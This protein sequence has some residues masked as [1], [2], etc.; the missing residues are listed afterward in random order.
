MKTKHFVALA[1]LPNLL[2]IPVLGFLLFDG[3]FFSKAPDSSFFEKPKSQDAKFSEPVRR[4]K[5][6]ADSNGDSLKQ[7][8]AAPVL[9]PVQMP[10]AMAAMDPNVFLIT[11]QQVAEWEALQDEFI[12][13]VG[14]K[15][16]SDPEEQ[17]RWEAARQM[18]DE[19]FRIKFGD[20]VFQKQLHAAAREKESAF[21]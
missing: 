4:A 18:S 1:A 15:M 17:K 3:T 12:S 9:E 7:I 10:A 2:L 8:S 5:S 11:E 19:M 21:P 13:E 6:Q 14:N 20:E 16:P